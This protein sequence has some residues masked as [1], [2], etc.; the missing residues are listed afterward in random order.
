MSDS[1]D[2]IVEEESS[3][4]TFLYVAG[5]LAAVML[6]AIIAIVVVALF[7]GNGE[8]AAIKAT[9][10]AIAFQNSLVTQTV[11]AMTQ[12]A[13][14]PRPTN[15]PLPP[16]YTPTPIPTFTPVPPTNTPT[17]VAQTP[18][19]ETPEGGGEAA[20]VETETPEVTPTLGPGG[21]ELPPGGL[22]MWGAVTAAVLLVGIIV[23][24]RRLRPAV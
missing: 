3:N 1:D 8:N 12:E 7:G 21:G 19:P 20:P 16:T 2:F 17:A 24:V 15:T 18:V 11:A 10:E 23:V 22:G 9:N 4:R 14:Q 13:N 5:G 6:L